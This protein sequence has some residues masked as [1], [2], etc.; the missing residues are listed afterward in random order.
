M[1][2]DQTSRSGRMPWSSMRSGPAVRS[3]SLWRSVMPSAAGQVAGPPAQALDAPRRRRR[4][5]ASDRGPRADRARRISTA[6]GRTC[7]L[8]DG[9]D[10]MV[11]SVVEVDVG[12]AGR[13]VQR[14]VAARRPRR[15]V[16]RRVVLADVGLGLDNHAGRRA[17]RATRGRAPC[18]SGRRAPPA[19]GG[20]RRLAAGAATAG[21]SQA[22]DGDGG[23]AAD[24][25][26]AVR[27][28]TPSWR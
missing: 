11:E 2:G 13:S 1:R 10:Q 28:R 15:G 8:R 26:V 12:A 20:R 9:V 14:R 21:P 5:R 16:A 6:A 24:A 19:W 4:R 18:Q 25:I 3:R 17:A 7:R 27:G 22:G 23:G